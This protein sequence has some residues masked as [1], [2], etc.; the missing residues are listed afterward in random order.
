MMTKRW[1]MSADGQGGAHKHEM[2][3]V[4]GQGNCR[5]AEASLEKSENERHG[6]Q[7]WT[8]TPFSPRSCQQWGLFGCKT[9]LGMETRWP[10]AV[11]L[12]L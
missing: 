2:I 9:P 3:D 8:W 7:Q 6:R 10:A 5:P 11:P 4:A 12:G 1:A